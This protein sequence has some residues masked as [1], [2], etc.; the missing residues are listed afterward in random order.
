M[1]ITLSLIHA[2]MRL[3]HVDVHELARNAGVP[4]QNLM[5]WLDNEPGHEKYLQARSQREVLRV[6]G[7]EDGRMRSDIVHYWH[8]EERYF[9]PAGRVYEA[10]VEVAK[11]AGP[12]EIVG[13]A[14][15]GGL[16]DGLANYGVFG[17]CWDGWRALVIVTTPLFRRIRLRPETLPDCTWL[18]FAQGRCLTVK[19]GT[20]FRVVEGDLTPTEFDCLTLGK[21]DTDE[22]ER[23]RLLARE[24]RLTASDVENW[25]LSQPDRRDTCVVDLT[26]ERKS[27]ASAKKRK[28]RATRTSP[29]A[30]AARTLG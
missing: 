12:C 10:L 8:M 17:L 25:I 7:I 6:L 30:T 26:A 3:K 16:T 23:V 2:L 21:C 9:A 5:R 13:V 27:R 19:R 4:E 24:A 1:K 14:P 15:E 28:P 18:D 20:F 22:W 29:A 11:A